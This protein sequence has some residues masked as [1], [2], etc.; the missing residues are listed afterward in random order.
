MSKIAM[1]FLISKL[2]HRGIVARPDVAGD[3]DNMRITGLTEDENRRVV[4]G[5]LDLGVKELPPGHI[6]VNL[7]VMVQ[8]IAR[9]MVN[10][11]E[12]A[13]ERRRKA[14]HD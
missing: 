2:N 10:E 1:D 13:E 8:L 9:F 5:L 4:A 14:W 12:L 3:Y 7:G 11:A 6:L